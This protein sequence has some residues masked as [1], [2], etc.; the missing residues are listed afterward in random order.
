MLAGSL[1]S[2]FSRRRDIQFTVIHKIE[3][4]NVSTVINRV[5]FEVW[6]GLVF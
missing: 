5:A 4:L 3:Q 1:P 2:I 6:F